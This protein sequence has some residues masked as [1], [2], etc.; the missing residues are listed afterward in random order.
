M[1]SVIGYKPVARKSKLQCYCTKAHYGT[2]FT[3][4]LSSVYVL[5]YSTASP[6]TLTLTLAISTSFVT[7]TPSI[8]ALPP[9]SSE[10][11]L[12]PS[13]LYLRSRHSLTFTSF[14]PIS[15]SAFTFTFTSTPLLPLT[16]DSIHSQ[17]SESRKLTWQVRPVL[18]RTAAFSCR[19]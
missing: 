17:E 13:P 9:P 11:R 6:C 4:L 1:V 5:L 8:V 10:H 19:W 12:R 14:S 7:L 2:F 18:V 15:V 16:L 3:S